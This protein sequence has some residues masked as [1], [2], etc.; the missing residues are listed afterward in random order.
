MCQNDFLLFPV[1]WNLIFHI[2]H[3]NSLTECFQCVR[4]HKE[5]ISYS[6]SQSLQIL[7]HED[8][9]SGS[10]RL[11]EPMG[12]RHRSVSDTQAAVGHHSES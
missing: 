6:D 5:A 11:K 7:G 2:Q 12:F 8:P 3:I 9:T 10:S 1:N 4:L